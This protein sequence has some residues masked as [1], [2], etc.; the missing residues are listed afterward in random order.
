[1]L[2][3]AFSGWAQ[4]RLATDPD[5]YDEPR[6]V[7]G[8]MMAYA[9]EPDLDRIIRFHH[10]PVTRSYTPAIGVN[11]TGI[12]LDAKAVPSH[13]LIG[14]KVDLLDNP[15]FEGRN[16]AISEDGL[17]PVTPFHLA[18]RQAGHH[19]SR[20][21]M[22][23][24]PTAPYREFNA[25]DMKRDLSFMQRAT[26][27]KSLIDVWAERLRD[28]KSDEARASAGERP[29]LLERIDF[30]ERN[31]ASGGG[32]GRFFPFRM[33]W[34]YQLRS[35]IKESQDGLKML[36]ADYPTTRE[37]WRVAFWFGGWDADAQ[38]FYVSG[39]LDIDRP[40]VEAAVTLARRPERMSDIGR[41]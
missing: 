9:G 31:L 7:S 38:A 37:P 34:D 14:A 28:L 4:C 16:G 2:S 41:V 13:P 39:V 21:T 6:G 19:F 40:A 11:V 3:V 27:V 5:P 25:S 29:G 10:P 17:E 33:E 23:S 24:D 35:E 18:L 36:L 30:L 20:A 15:V 26:G 32:A 22:A 12:H 1:M 8:Y